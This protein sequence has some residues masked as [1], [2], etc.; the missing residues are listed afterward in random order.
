MQIIGHRGARRLALENTVEAL[1]IAFEEGADGV[2][3]DVRLSGDGEPVVWHDDDL[4]PWGGGALIVGQTPWRNLRDVSL[5]DAQGHRGRIAHLD[6]VL[7]LLEH[8]SGPINPE[9]K[10]GHGPAQDAVSLAEAVAARMAHL[11]AGGWVASSFDLRAIETLAV[12]SPSMGLAALVRSLPCDFEMLASSQRDQ[13]ERAMVALQANLPRPITALH[14]EVAL[15]D[16]TRVAAW[17]AHDLAVLV[18]TA[19]K[20]STWARLLELEVDAAITDDPGALRRAMDRDGVVR[21]DP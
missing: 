3:F 21:R 13:S 11:S 1:Q 2:E 17:R 5:A 6:E 18:W 8:R 10:V 4:R 14:A 15:T 7:E 12:A 19:N 16:A 9:L 20:P